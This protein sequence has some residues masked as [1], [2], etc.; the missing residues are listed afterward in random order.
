MLRKCLYF[1]ERG[2]KVNNVGNLRVTRFI[3]T[4][5]QNVFF[6][7]QL[8]WNMIMFG[9]FMLQLM[10]FVKRDNSNMVCSNNNQESNNDSL[11]KHQ[12]LLHINISICPEINNFAEG[13]S[14][15]VFES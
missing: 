12:F 9:N 6:S 14:F 2:K 3:S 1:K 8:R 11:N 13:K 4:M 15:K 10:Q 5:K 7:F